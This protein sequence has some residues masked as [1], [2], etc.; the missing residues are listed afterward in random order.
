MD[1]TRIVLYDRHGAINATL[2]QPG[3][4]RSADLTGWR[5]SRLEPRGSRTTAQ[6]IWV[7][8]LDRQTTTRITTHPLLDAS[9]V[10]SRDD[11]YT[12]YRL[13]WVGCGSDDIFFGGA[14]AFVERLKSATIP[15][16]SSFQV[17][18]PHAMPVARVDWPECCRC[19]FGRKSR[20][21]AT[22]S[23]R[24]SI[25]VLTRAT[26]PSRCATAKPPRKL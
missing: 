15:H 20:V 3:N 19:Y 8:D 6:D 10:W 17:S 13:I 5:E 26:C 2:A 16:I 24:S 21:C 11:I 4:Y 1:P 23:R 14:K 25:I 18:G 22:L 7:F 9:P 12:N